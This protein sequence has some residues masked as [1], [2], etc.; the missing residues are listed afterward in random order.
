M[1]VADDVSE[2]RDTSMSYVG[3]KKGATNFNT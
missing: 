3:K 2:I 1:D